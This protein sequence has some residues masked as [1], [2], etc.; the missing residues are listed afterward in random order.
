MELG[1]Q[2]ESHRALGSWGDGADGGS[3]EGSQPDL[4]GC[5]GRGIYTRTTFDGNTARFTCTMNGMTYSFEDLQ[6]VDRSRA[7]R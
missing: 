3:R 4:T 6:L 7:P 5:K 2:A 1:Q